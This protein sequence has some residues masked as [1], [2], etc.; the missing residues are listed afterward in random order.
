MLVEASLAYCCHGRQKV[1]IPKCDQTGGPPLRSFL[2][3]HT[4]EAWVAFW[5]EFHFKHSLPCF[6]L[7]L[8]LSVYLNVICLV[9][10]Y[11]IG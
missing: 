5:Q 1:L 7:I 9:Y 8:F 2:L 3:G 10:F 11:Q 6:C 4:R